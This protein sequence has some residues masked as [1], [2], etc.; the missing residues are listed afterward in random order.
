MREV[1]AGMAQVILSLVPLQTLALAIA[2]GQE[3]F[4]WRLLIGSLLAA[5]GVALVFARQVDAGVPLPALVSVAL[6]GMGFAEGAILVKRFP[7][8]DPIATNA[9]AMAVGAAIL[10]VISRLSGEEAALPSRTSTWLALGYLVLLGSCLV[11]VLVLFILRFWPASKM[12]YQFVLLPFVAVTA[13]SLLENERL[14]PIL[15]AGAALVITG[16]YLGAFAP[17]ASKPVRPTDSP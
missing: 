2:Q 4:R 7:R 3:R 8:S 15:L 13:S 16:V 14:S 17:E 5:A 10:F 9:V 1:Q 12:A 11:F 6:G